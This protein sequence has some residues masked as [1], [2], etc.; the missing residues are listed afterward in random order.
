MRVIA[1]TGGIATGKSTVSARWASTIPVI[2]ADDVAHK[3][4][5][6]APVKKELVESFGPGILSGEMIDRKALGQIVFSDS[7]SRA[8]VEEIVHPHVKA[9][10]ENVIELL[11]AMGHNLICYDVPLLFETCSEN[12]YDAVIVVTTRPDIQL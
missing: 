3:M 11:Q 7:S 12:N 9:T 10:V 5:D 8:I 2:D 1:L 4:L 6:Y